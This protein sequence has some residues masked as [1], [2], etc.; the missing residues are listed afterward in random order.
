[1]KMLYDM[2]PL[3]IFMGALM[4]SDI[5]TATAALVVATIVQN[6]WT[7]IRHRRI[8]RMHMITM[9]AV[10]V[11]G[12]LTLIL[13]DIRFIKWKPSIVNWIFAGIMLY[14][15]WFTAKSALER[16]LGAQMKM[17]HHAWN[18]LNFSWAIFFV[19]VGLLNLYVAFIYGTPADP[20]ASVYGGPIA[21]A[22]IRDRHWGYFKVFGLMALTMVFALTSFMSM[23]KHIE[24]P[25][26]SKDAEGNTTDDAN[27]RDDDGDSSRPV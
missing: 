11:F 24:M 4:L 17:P 9:V 20:I 25:D 2:F 5:K 19:F 12:G 18:K 26:D 15:Q 14:M 6:A 27:N 8:E 21:D 7:W 10:L 22:E 3:A 16:M 23:A 1:M 13:D